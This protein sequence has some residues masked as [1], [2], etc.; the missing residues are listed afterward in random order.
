MLN[1]FYRLSFHLACSGNDDTQLAQFATDNNFATISSCGDQLVAEMCDH[2]THGTQLKQI[3]P[4]TCRMRNYNIF[5]FQIVLHDLR[6]QTVS[7]SANL[8]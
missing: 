3:C 5:L 2:E 7:C 6:Y 1:K 8:F 4:C